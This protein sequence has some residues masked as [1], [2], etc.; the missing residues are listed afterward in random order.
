MAIVKEPLEPIKDHL[1]CLSL[2]VYHYIVITISLITDKF[3][4]KP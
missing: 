2:V 3:I 1:G 4:N